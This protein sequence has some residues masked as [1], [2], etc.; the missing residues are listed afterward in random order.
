M[1]FPKEGG[2]VAE[3][4]NRRRIYFL[5][6]ESNS[7][8]KGRE[9][10]QQDVSMR[11]KGIHL[12]AEHGWVKTTRR[13]DRVEKPSNERILVEPKKFLQKENN[14]EQ[15]DQSMVIQKKKGEDPDTKKGGSPLRNRDGGWARAGS[16]H[17]GSLQRGKQTGCVGIMRRDQS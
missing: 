9:G 1:N 12:G 15:S 14:G 16:L 7:H 11:E 4:E 13:L 8:L 2:G 6:G 3:G 5:G 17:H 10:T